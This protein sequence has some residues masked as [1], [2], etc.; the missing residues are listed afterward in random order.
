MR[1]DGDPH[2][3]EER[4]V[5]LLDAAARVFAREPYGQASMDD[6]AHEA[7]VGKPTLYR[8]YPGKDALFAAVFAESLAEIETQLLAV[9][10]REAGIEERLSGLIAA[11]VPVFRDHL[12]PLRLLDA[13]AASADQS[14]RRV[15]R[16]NRA[17]IARPLAT[18]IDEAAAS[19]E[20]GPAQGDTISEL[21]IGMI[22]SACASF[23]GGD[24]R[25]ISRTVTDLVLRGLLPRE[26][27]P[28]A[29]TDWTP[30][31]GEA[32]TALLEETR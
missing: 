21:I 31:R 5:R 20:I 13:S 11:I 16:Q 10:H 8:Y 4:R 24:A 30:R 19:G 27:E 1:A 7:G 32:R 26:A 2:W 18:A 15:F 14:K 23:G 3:R 6:I 9:L 25:A 22:W 12:V 17:R 28:A 29:P